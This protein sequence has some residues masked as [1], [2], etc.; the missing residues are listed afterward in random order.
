M[1]VTRTE[2]ISAKSRFGVAGTSTAVGLRE[3]AGGL[4]QPGNER[5]TTMNLQ[6][7]FLLSATS[8]VFA[9]AT[10]CAAPTDAQTDDGVSSDESEL[11]GQ[12]RFTC[13]AQYEGN[14][15]A[16]ELT[17][18]VSTLSASVFIGNEGAQRGKIDPS[19]TPRTNSAYYRYLVNPSD[20]SSGYL[21]VQ[22]SLL[23]GH[24]GTLQIRMDYDE[25]GGTEKFDCTP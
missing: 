21:L 14:G 7:F 16:D 25:G 18:R 13:T 17:L 2:H 6:S 4:A 23:S 15:I 3:C 9:L 22:K 10:G 11:R 24:P 19:Y 5:T 1:E 12:R 20:A 8:I